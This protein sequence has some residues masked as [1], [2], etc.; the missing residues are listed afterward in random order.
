[1]IDKDV[2][3]DKFDV[4]RTIESKSNGAVFLN[5]TEVETYERCLRFC[6]ET[7]MCS[8]AVWDQQVTSPNP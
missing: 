6:C 7:P 3:F 8:V 5:N 1:M 4:A 2:T